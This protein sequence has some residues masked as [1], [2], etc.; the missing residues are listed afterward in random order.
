[1]AM[2]VLPALLIVNNVMPMEHADHARM[3]IKKLASMD[4]LVLFAKEN[5][6]M[7]VLRKMFVLLMDFAQKLDN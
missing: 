1:M 3:T 2:L 4:Y 6:V 7:F 5:S